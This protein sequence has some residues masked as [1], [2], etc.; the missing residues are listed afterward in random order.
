MKVKGEVNLASVLRQL[1]FDCG[2]MTSC[3]MNLNSVPGLHLSVAAAL[4]VGGLILA[5]RELK[6]RSA[7]SLPWLS[8]RGGGESG[9]LVLVV[10]GLQNLG[11]NCFLNVILQ[12]LCIQLLRATTNLF[13]DLIKLEGHIS[14]PL[15]LNLC[16]LMKNGMET[17]YMGSTQRW[18]AKDQSQR[19]YPLPL[20]NRQLDMG[21]LSHM[22]FPHQETQHSKTKKNSETSDDK[23]L[24]SADEHT[25]QEVMDK[26]TTEITACRDSRTES[27]I[28]QHRNEALAEV[29][30]QAPRASPIYRLVSVVEHMGKTGGGHY[31]V[32]RRMRSQVDEE[33]TD[34][35]NMASSDQWVL[36]S[37][38][39][40]HQVL[41]SDVLAAQASILFYERVTVR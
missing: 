41:E 19:L 16:S 28:E 38:S 34:S 13:G 29:L 11:N 1:R 26:H 32:Y 9:K 6:M 39:D 27:E 21:V 36:I 4:T 23:P 3:K 35:G 8:G 7:C 33:E 30:Q 31:T 10:P 12:I 14:F 20:V 2:S 37:D 18:H 15:I 40:V 25:N 17:V 5:L 24:V 22:C